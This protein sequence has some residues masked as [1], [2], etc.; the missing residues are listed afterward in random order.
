MLSNRQTRLLS[1]VEDPRCLFSDNTLT[2]I[3]NIL[4]S[5]TFNH[6]TM[7]LVLTKKAN[8]V[9]L[10]QFTFTIMSI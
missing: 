4:I 2:L 1:N 6:N 7:L 10:T 8:L 3:N 9:L 5:H